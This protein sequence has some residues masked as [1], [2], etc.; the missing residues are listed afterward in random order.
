MTDC[1]TT[2]PDY[3]LDRAAKSPSAMAYWR[4]TPDGWQGETWQS[5]LARVRRLSGHLLRAG[6][7]PGDRVAIMMPTSVEW[8]LCHLAVLSSGCAIVGLDAH[9]SPVNITHILHTV[10][11]RGL[12]VAT[13]EQGASLQA[14][15]SAPL[16]VCLV[17]ATGPGDAGHSLV[18][19]LQQPCDVPDNWP[20]ATADRTATII[21]TSGSTG[22]PKGIAYDHRQLCLACVS[23]LD[24]FPSIGAGARFACW[25]PLS[26]LF[27]RIINLC[28][29]IRGGESYFVETPTQIVERL[30]QIAPSIFI[31]VPRFF[32]KLHAGIEANL[33]RQPAPIR[34]G[35]RWARRIGM[36]YRRHE[37]AGQSPGLLLSLAHG[38]ADRLF[39]RHI[40]QLTGPDLQFMVSGSAPLPPWLMESLHGIG[41]LV[42]EAYGT[43]ENV[44][45][46]AINAPGAYRFGSVGQPMPQNEISIANDGE[47]LVRGAGVFTGYFGET[48]AEAALDSD[49]FL[50][51]GDYARLD[52]Q[53][54]LWLAGRKSEIFKTSTGR[55]IAPTPVEARLKQL[56]YVE[57]A[58]LLG[59]EMPV[60]IALL[61][62]NPAA[63]PGTLDADGK[64]G[65]TLTEKIGKEIQTVCSDL[66]ARD[67]PAGALITR[68]PFTIS[69]GELTSN[70]K[71]RRAPIEEKYRAG[72]ADLY[73]A[74]GDRTDESRI[75]VREAP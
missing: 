4:D 34:L 11:P 64:L 49:G 38:I 72:I 63:L 10:A 29:M 18:E 61:S 55:R 56:P 73:R 51:T 28:G 17:N 13:A 2:I 9:D 60:P 53:G 40:R 8:E 42:L 74:L 3:L 43:S 46:I 44:V 59:R 1:P 50:H 69:G 25:L 12:I 52:E 62:V 7:V 65:P 41:W 16:A 67:R 15:I 32:E 37:R 48:P 20:L 75:L 54:Y 71:L 35:M 23:I 39:L 45:P 58:V 5:V 33:A 57:F 21:F 14:L 47:L 24:R 26:N 22:Q 70:L 19:W 31:G 27:Q 36:A 66:A 30:P 68:E 6:L